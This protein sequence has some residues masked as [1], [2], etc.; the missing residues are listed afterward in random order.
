[1]KN[2]FK[3]KTFEEQVA[4]WGSVEKLENLKLILQTLNSGVAFIYNDDDLVVGYRI[5][6]GDEENHFTSD[7][8][9]FDWP[10]QHMPVPEAMQG[11]VH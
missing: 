1:M 9:I 4:T 2:L 7:P 3:K 11:A 6:F 10:M 5:M 8:I